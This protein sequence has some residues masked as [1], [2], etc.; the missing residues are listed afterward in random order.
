FS[1]PHWSAPALAPGAVVTAR[2]ILR[3]WEAW[4]SARRRFAW[5]ALALG[6]ALSAG[7]HALVF[8]A[9]SVPRGLAYRPER[10]KLTTDSLDQFC[11]WPELAARLRGMEGHEFDPP[12]EPIVCDSYTVASLIAFYSK[13]RYEPLLLASGGGVHGFSYLYWQNPAR[14]IGRRG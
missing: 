1:A 7:A 12:E 13:G 11:G 14:F 3:R 8:L 10:R 5:A 4:R 2:W 9:G 6:L